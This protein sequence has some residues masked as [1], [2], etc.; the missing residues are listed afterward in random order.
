MRR[1]F[2]HC[3]DSRI[4][5]TGTWY[6]RLHLGPFPTGL[7]TTLATALRR[8]RLL[9]LPFYGVEAIEIEG[10]RHEYSRLPG[11]H[12]PVLDLLLRFRELALSGTLEASVEADSDSVFGFFEARGPGVLRAGDLRLPAGLSCANPGLVLANLAPGAFLRGRI[13]IERR[14]GQE[15]AKPT[16]GNWLFVKTRTGP[17][18]RAG[19]RIEDV[20]PLDQAGERVVFEI[21]TNGTLSP[22][23]ALRQAA[24]RLVRLFL[25]IV[26]L[27]TVP[28]RFPVQPTIFT[29]PASLSKGAPFLISSGSEKT[30]GVAAFQGYRR[31]AEPLGLD[32][33][34]LDLS[35]STYQY[36]RS[37][38]VAT[39]G[40]LLDFLANEST[41]PSS[42]AEEAQEA[43][44]RFGLVSFLSFL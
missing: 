4:E 1:I 8:T 21:S 5:E 19:F 18:R 33:G 32:L 14:N 34:N 36:F 10:A 24:E 38:G 37:Q 26:G 17:I 28:E 3:V 40:E 7:A 11:I 29:K 25:G 23:Q 39:R 35:F 15:P 9:D 42:H 2:L 6:S 13:L 16:D 31:Y 43:L 41:L 44:R 27:D 12:E 30:R 20:G 22:N